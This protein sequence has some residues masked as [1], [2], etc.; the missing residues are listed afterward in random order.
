MLN[1]EFLVSRELILVV[2]NPQYKY[3]Y[4]KEWGMTILT[5]SWVTDSV[6]KG[7][8][9]LVT[10]KKYQVADTETGIVELSDLKLA[11]DVYRWSVQ[12]IVAAFQIANSTKEKDSTLPE[13]IPEE[14]KAF[15]IVSEIAQ[16]VE[17]T[18]TGLDLFEEMFFF[19]SGF[20]SELRDEIS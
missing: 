15:D 4:A 16:L 20:D 10:R 3:K 6:A 13:A 2:G 19:I 17:N 18:V 8:G 14:T 1:S 11:V 12:L 5:T 7:F 9:Q